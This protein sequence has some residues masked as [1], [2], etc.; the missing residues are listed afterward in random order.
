M[1]K[2]KSKLINIINVI[3]DKSVAQKSSNVMG[4]KKPFGNMSALTRQVAT[5]GAVLLENDEALPQLRSHTRRD[6][7]L[8]SIT[9]KPS[10]CLKRQAFR[11][12]SAATADIS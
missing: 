4:E 11:Y 3:N 7:V 6:T 1:D 12:G 9:L 2:L 8:C 5:E 10:R